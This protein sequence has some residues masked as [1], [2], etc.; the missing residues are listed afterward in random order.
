MARQII[1]TP[2]HSL[3]T[4]AHLQAALGPLRVQRLQAWA[5]ARTDEALGNVFGR[6]A[7]QLGWAGHNA[8]E[9][10]RVAHRW[11]ALHE[12]GGGDCALPCAPHLAFDSRAWPWPQEALDVVVLAHTLERSADAR[13]CLREVARVLAPEGVVCIVGL[14]PWGSWAARWRWHGRTAR[15]PQAGAA[16]AL[17]GLSALREWL[18]V[19]G[20]QVQA[21]HTLGG[22]RVGGGWVLGAQAYVLVARKRVAGLRALP[23]RAWRVQPVWGGPAPPVAV[24]QGAAAGRSGRSQG[25]A[26]FSLSNGF[27]SDHP[28]D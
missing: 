15:Q 7:L 11:L 18:S 1:E 10:S 26:S 28:R 9:R 14:N 5:Q 2:P 20:L 24:Q 16:P 3:S 21:Q 12:G 23:G 19:L 17:L 22:W 25:F 13:A 27:E 8:L 4:H 6:C